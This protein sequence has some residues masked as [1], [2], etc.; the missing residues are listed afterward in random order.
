MDHQG[1]FAMLVMD[2]LGAE[3][4]KD[5]EWSNPRLICIAGYFTKYDEYA[6]K[7]INRNIELI[8]YRRYGDELILFE[9]VHVVSA[10]TTTTSSQ[11][12]TTTTFKKP[13]DYLKQATQQLSDVYE[14]LS[15][16]L[17]NL[18][19]DV[20][21]KQLKYYIAF[22]RIR[23]FACVEVDPQA[24]KL[25]IFV[26]VNPN[27]VELRNGF[28]QDVRTIGHFGTGDLE[29]TLTSMDD[30]EAAKPL[31]VKSYEAS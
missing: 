9:L 18:G 15:A 25:L 17:T 23:N 10:E 28:T 3:V 20:Q 13:L 5:I 14:A 1:A 24:N 12:K 11:T 6:V 26:K 8:R 22:K 16:F 21:I 29:I 7:Q 27:N 4:M 2:R 31:I 19:D 30:L